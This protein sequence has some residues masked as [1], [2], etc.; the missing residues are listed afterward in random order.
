MPSIR[1]C[2]SG[3]TKEGLSHHSG[4]DSRYLSIRHSERLAECA[5]QASVGTAGDSYNNAMAETNSGLYK[6]EI[7]WRRGPW[8]GLETVEHATLEWVY[9]F[10]NR[11]LLESIGDAPPAEFEQ[12]YYE[13]HESVALAA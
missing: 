10:D 11:R 13:Q 8:R 2:M 5:I 7:I 3:R 12:A 1:H 9:W 4:R 6:A